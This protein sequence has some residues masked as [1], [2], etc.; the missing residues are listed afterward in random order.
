MEKIIF[1]GLG[2]DFERINDFFERRFEVV[3]YSDKREKRLRTILPTQAL[4]LMIFI[5]HFASL[6][7]RMKRHLRILEKI[8]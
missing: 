5:Q 7:V 4:R 8:Q 6:Q 2:V 1:Y 3:G